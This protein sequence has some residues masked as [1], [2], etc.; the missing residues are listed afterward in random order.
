MKV[1]ISFFLLVMML[2]SCTNE[3]VVSDL[4]LWYSEPATK[5]EE[6]LP[7]GNG[8]LGAM[9]YGN[10]TNELI[11]LNENTIWAGSPNRNDNP[12]ALK[13]LPL[14]R[15]LIFEGKYVEAQDLANEKIISKK[16]HGMPYQTAGNLRLNFDGHADYSEFYRDLDIE[17]AVATTRYMVGEVEYTREVFSSFSDEVIVVRLTANKPNALSFVS[18]LDRP[19]EVE[20]SVVEKDLLQM[21]GVT[22]SFE[23]VEGKVEFV[24]LSK[25]VND[26]GELSATNKE[27][28]VEG[29]NSVTIFVSIG[30]NFVNYNDLSANASE[31]AEAYLS[32]AV[33]SDYKE[34]LK[35]HTAFYQ[36]YFNRVS[37]NLGQTDSINNPT[38]IRIEQ[39]SKGNDPSMAALYFQFGRYLLISSSQPGTQAANLQGVWNDQLFPAWD[40]KYTL[41]INAEMNYWPAEPTNLAELHEPMIDMVKELSVAGQKTAE[42]MYGAKGWVVHHNTDIWRITGPVDGSYWGMWPMGGV[43]L[44]QHLFDKY[45]YGGDTDY[46]RSIYGILKGAVEFCLDYMVEDPE[47]GWMVVVPSNSP[48]N[49]PSIHHQ[50]SIA[51]GATM[52]NQL[53]FDLFT[54]TIQAAQILSIDEPLLPEMKR[55]LSLLPPMQ[56]GQYGQLQEWMHDWDNPNDKHRHVSHLYGLFPSNQISPFYTPELADAART[57]LIHRGDPSTGWSIN[58]KINLWARLLDGNHAFELMQEQIK[59]VGRDGSN[60]AVFERGGTYPN[61]F[62]AHP[63]F[64]IDGNFGFTSGLTEMLMQSHDGAVHLLPAL[65]DVWPNGQIKGLRARGGFEIIELEWEKHQIKKLVVKSTLGGN[66]RLRASNELKVK[67][68]GALADVK[69]NNSNPFYQLPTTKSA[70]ISP[71]AQLNS[72][73]LPLSH[74][75]DIETVEGEIY[76]FVPRESL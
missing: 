26:G 33:E 72:F 40:S 6:A 62:D 19:G 13:A 18:T 14:I 2:C 32:K 8:R 46:L 45:E 11:Q 69:E 43:W 3:Q 9:V 16:S 30:T 4:K 63:P 76:T 44:S 74:L 36:N 66:L 10:P 37:L 17:R 67:A 52:D 56:I 25:F 34:M 41:N 51:A 59:L 50:S 71:S 20:V 55:T 49:S 7:L 75:Y 1:I 12:D 60:R 53:V 21:K 24:V 35:D 27:I 39:F 68:N 70:L 58:W 42:A 29:A 64:Q 57:S 31:R 48:E 54:K 61:M 28:S 23:T 47:N 38:D 15:Q 22:S 65:P 5:F 73:D